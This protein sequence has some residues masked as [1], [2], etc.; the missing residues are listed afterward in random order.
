MTQVANEIRVR[1]PTVEGIAIVQRIGQLQ[2]GTPTVLIACT[3]THRNADF[4]DAALYG[5]DRLI[6]IVP[7]WE[8][9]IGP[10]GDL[11]GGDKPS[12]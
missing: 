2:A 5:I 4:Y 6:E 12:G 3:V 8:N 10:N 9:E 7:I 11:G 1:W